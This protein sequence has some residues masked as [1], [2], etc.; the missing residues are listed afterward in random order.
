LLSKV[1]LKKKA[2][3]EKAVEYIQDGMTIGLGSGSTVY[4]MMKKLGK[5]VENG[6]NVRGVPSSL[7]TEG[8]AK[9]FGVPLVYF[10]EVSRLD[11]A[12]DGADEV[13]PDFN[14]SKGG[15]GSLLREKLV[16]DA[17][18]ELIIVVDDSKL[19]KNLGAFPLP[20]EIV[21]FGWEN[22]AR[23]IEKL[24]CTPMLRKNE[25][26]VFISNN[27]NYIVDC[28]FTSIADPAAL[29]QQLKLLLGVIETGLFVNMTD[30]V[31]VGMDKGIKILDKGK[32]LC[33]E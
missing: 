26:K 15:G 30:K 24:G 2:V 27:G 23:K 8:W 16:N 21:P 11:L 32:V 12:I 25:G 10:S 1:D 7:R 6:L 5:L 18:D 19:V 4:W 28:R 17:A 13:D 31:I 29:H 9:E 14:L 33:D 22:T 20:V 3:G